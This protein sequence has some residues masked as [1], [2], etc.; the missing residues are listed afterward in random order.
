M[1]IKTMVPHGFTIFWFR[2]ARLEITYLHQKISPAYDMAVFD[3]ITSINPDVY[4]NLKYCT[5]NSWTDITG[6]Q[7]E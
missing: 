1:F 5:V 3:D 4:S 7:F 6:A 2:I